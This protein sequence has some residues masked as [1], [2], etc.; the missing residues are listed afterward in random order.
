MNA[1]GHALVTVAPREM[2]QFTELNNFEEVQG[3]AYL[4]SAIEEIERYMSAD[5]L[6]PSYHNAITISGIEVRWIGWV[7]KGRALADEFGVRSG[8]RSSR[9]PVSFRLTVW[10]S[11]ATLGAFSLSSSQLEL[12]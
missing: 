7:Q 3:N 2:G 11:S 8:R 6:V 1:L 9:W 5:R 4:Q 10:S 12:S